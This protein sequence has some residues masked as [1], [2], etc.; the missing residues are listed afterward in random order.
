MVLNVDIIGLC[1][2][3]TFFKEIYVM[4]HKCHVWW[5]NF[6]VKPML[7]TGLNRL[8]LVGRSGR[9]GI[10]TQILFMN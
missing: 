9:E 4:Q 8:W 3:V 6:H 5:H 2:N 10:Y 7:I 1:H